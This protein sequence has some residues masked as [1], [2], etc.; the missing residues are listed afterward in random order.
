MRDYDLIREKYEQE[1]NERK[2][3]YHVC[4]TLQVD[5]EVDIPLPEGMTEADVTD[6][7]VQA[8]AEEALAEGRFSDVDLWDW[9]E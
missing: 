7:V 3:M 1:E 9:T 6:D 8:A 5:V 4:A 2:G